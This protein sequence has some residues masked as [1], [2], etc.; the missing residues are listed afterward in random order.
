MQRNYKDV[1]RIAVAVDCIVFGFDG[2]SLSVL[3]IKRRIDPMLGQWSLVGSFIKKEEDL[4][5][6]AERI[7]NT[8]TGLEN[9]YF[10]QL[11]SYGEVNRDPVER[12]LSIS[13]FALINVHSQDSNTLEKHHASWHK[14]DA[15]PKLIFD[16][17]EMIA[18]AL[19]Q[20]RYKAA[21]HPIG[22]ELLPKEFTLPQWQ[23]L[24]EAIYNKAI[25]RR[26]FSKKLLSMD[27]LVPTGKLSTDSATKKA[28]LYKIDTAKYKK[29]LKTAQPI[30]KYCP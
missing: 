27:I 14:V 18:L 6:A 3:L 21:L 26:N 5:K 23:S 11:H 29:A 12:T 22:R 24:Y 1:E 16:H 7:L 8:F 4:Q 2:R 15:L 19:E 30:I 10:E 25:D 9:V 28:V 13:H 17:K 20:L